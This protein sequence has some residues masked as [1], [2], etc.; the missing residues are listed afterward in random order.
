MI[1]EYLGD[2]AYATI[3]RDF[4]GQ[5]IL[6]ANHHDPARATDTVHLD[7]G[8]LDLLVKLVKRAQG[9]EGE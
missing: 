5:I 8:A 3:N 9:V 2:G 4:A 6:T 7:D 1:V